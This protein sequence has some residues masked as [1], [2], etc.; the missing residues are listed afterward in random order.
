VSSKNDKPFEVGTYKD[1]EQAKQY[2]DKNTSDSISYY[3][4]TDENRILYSSN[5]IK[6][7]ELNA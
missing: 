2:V 1:F 5:D 4:N 7:G 3:V 6:R